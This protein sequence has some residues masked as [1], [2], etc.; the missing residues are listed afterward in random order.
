MLT[1]ALGTLIK[2]TENENFVFKITLPYFD[3]EQSTSITISK[4][5]SNK[6]FLTLHLFH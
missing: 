2:D 3:P 6:T 5:D 1:S 4:I